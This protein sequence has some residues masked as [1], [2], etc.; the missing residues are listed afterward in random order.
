MTKDLATITEFNF[1]NA[2]IRTATL[3]GEPMFC[4][5]D[6]AEVLDIKNPRDGIA[7]RKGVGTI[8][9]FTDMG[10][11]PTTFINEANLYRLIFK[12][13][14]PNAEA[15]QEWVTSEVLPAIRKTGNFIAK[16]LSTLDMIIAS[17]MEL[18]AVEERLAVTESRLTAIENNHGSHVSYMT[19]VGYCKTNGMALT[20]GEAS[21]LGKLLSRKCKEEGV[22]RGEVPDEH[23]GTVNTYPITMLDEY[24]ENYLAEQRQ[25]V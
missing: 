3:D 16:P 2:Q 24:V 4:L 15:F 21:Q 10:I 23:W 22:T 14:K 18:K 9:T 11:R 12:S 1:G 17:A 7:N 20:R 13:R 8:D 5:K 19:I 6:V 25:Y